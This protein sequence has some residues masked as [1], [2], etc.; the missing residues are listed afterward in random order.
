MTNASDQ[1]NSGDKRRDR[2]DLRLRISTCTYVKHAQITYL[3]H[4]NGQKTHACT[5]L[6][7]KRRKKTPASVVTRT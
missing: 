3:G 2:F 7:K 6:K 5:R 1:H 4:P